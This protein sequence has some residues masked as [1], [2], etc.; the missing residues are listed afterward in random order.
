MVV[1]SIKI[2]AIILTGTGNKAHQANKCRKGN[3]LPL[4]AE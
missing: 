3:L 1:N 4:Y 2:S